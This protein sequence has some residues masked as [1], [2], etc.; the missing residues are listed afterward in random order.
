MKI[1]TDEKTIESV[2]TRGVEQVFPD[3]E[4]LKELLLSGKQIKLY[5][6]FDPTALSLHI[7]NAIQINKLAQFQK[8]GHKVIFLVGDFT[9]LIGDPT[10][11][12]AVRPT[13]TREQILENCK[14]YKQQAEMFLNFEGDNPAEIL[15]NS[16]WNDNLPFKSLI[17]LASHFT[18]QRM[19]KRDMFEK[20]LKDEKPIYLHEFLYPLAQAYDSVALNVDLELGGNDQM[21]NM[22]CGRD[23]QKAINKKEK[24]VLTLKLLAD[25]GG[26]KMGKTEENAVFLDQQPQ[27]IYGAIM[28]WP[29]G[30]IANTFELITDMPMEEIEKIRIQIKDGTVNPKDLKMKLARELVKIFHGENEVIPSEQAFVEQFQKKIIPENVLEIS[31]KDSLEI[32][33]LLVEIGLTKSKGEARRKIDEGAVKIDDE[34]ITD[35]KY[36]MDFGDKTEKIIKLGRKI[37]KIYPIK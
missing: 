17:E 7:G 13:M 11:K 22:M 5:C 14:N 28:S 23:L 18:A 32:L 25:E 19:L 34:K 21:F 10:D 1:N 31:V 6:G 8:L 4:K 26:K 20:R 24:F 35:Q 16:D 15:Y 30:F 37:I 2:L 33:D 12:T 9:A 27:D 36:A 3:K 29:D